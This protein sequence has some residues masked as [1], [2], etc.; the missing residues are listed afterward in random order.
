MNEQSLIEEAKS[1][2]MKAEERNIKLRILGA[3]AIKL[4]SPRFS[5]LQEKLNR[6]LT[7]IDLVGY[8]IQRNEIINFM[9]EN[10]YEI[11]RELL[12]YVALSP[13]LIFKAKTGNFKIDVFLDKLEMCHTIDF[14]KRLEIDHPTISLSDLLLEKLQIVKI[15]RK[16]IIDTIVL[17]RE[18]EIGDREEKEKI[19]MKYIAFVLTRDW[20]FYHTVTQ[21]LHKILNML[22]EIEQLSSEDVEDLRNKIERILQYLASEPKNL[23]W[24]VRAIV[25]TRLKWYNEVEEILR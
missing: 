21:N 5:S 14:R 9:L 16:D 10:K 25:G 6:R 1:I 2:V 15:N 4:H 12:D 17:L 7:D 23:K 13:R 20:G 18:H 19:N 11:D 24:K 22:Y 8:S 3:V